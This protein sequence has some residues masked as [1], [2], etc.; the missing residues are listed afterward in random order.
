MSPLRTLRSRSILLVALPVIAG[1][2]AIGMELPNYGF[3]GFA[4]RPDGAKL[5][6]MLAAEQAEGVVGNPPP[7]L[8]EATFTLDTVMVDGKEAWLLTR[9]RSGKGVTT[10]VD[11]AWLDRW[12]LRPIMTWGSTPK[13]ELRMKYDRR[14]VSRERFSKGRRQGGGRILLDAEPYAEP[15]I[16]LV[17]ASMP[18]KEDFG[19]SLPI[20]SP[21][22]PDELSWLRFRVAQ[23]AVAPADN[24]VMRTVFV[25]EG[26]VN[27]VVRRYWI[28]ADDRSV[29]KWEEPGPDGTTI[30]WSR[31]RAQPR[32]KVFEVEKL[33]G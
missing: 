5:R 30:R 8:G 9:S 31:G 28:D 4:P 19:G 25:V 33:G 17:I 18:L 22:K 14:S 32:L 23:R 1:C 3:Y 11:S 7:V 26:D 24:G 27:G 15:G 10:Q 2:S 13:G 20:V 21:L 6:T 16:E 12:S 29:I